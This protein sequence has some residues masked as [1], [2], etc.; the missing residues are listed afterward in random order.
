ME[1]KQARYLHKML[2][3]LAEGK[4]LSPEEITLLRKNLPELPKQKTLE[5]IAWDMDFA[6]SETFGNDWKE[7]LFGDLE[8]WLSEQ[9]NQLRAHLEGVKSQA[10]PALPAGMR[11]AEHEN[12]GRVV[13]SPGVGVDTCHEIFYIEPG[14][15]FAT[16]ISEVEPDSLTFLDNE[17]AQ[18]APPA[19]PVSMRL[20]DHKNFGRVVVATDWN[21][22]HG[23]NFCV[24][25]NSRHGCVEYSYLSADSLTFI[26]SEP[27]HPE[28]LETEEDY[29]SAPTSTIVADADKHPWTKESLGWRHGSATGAA[30]LASPNLQGKR[31]VLRWGEGNE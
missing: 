5:E 12:F 16:G 22:H 21:N 26:D 11:I 31:R 18:S 9:H 7:E 29:Q 25:F 28:F 14:M 1:I 19:L 13:V 6:W 8:T 2:D 24:F 27:A 23:E 30:A 17:P 3:R 20:A 4:S 15:K 10:H